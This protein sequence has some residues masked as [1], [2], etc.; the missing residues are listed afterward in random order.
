LAVLSVFRSE[1]VDLQKAIVN[2]LPKFEEQQT[3]FISQQLL[4]L[5]GKECQLTQMRV[6]P[7]KPK[8]PTEYDFWGLLP[9]QHSDFLDPFAAIDLLGDARAGGLRPFDIMLEAK[10]KDL[11]L[12][13]LREQIV[14]FAPELVGYIGWLV[15]D[16]KLTCPGEH[17]AAPSP[18]GQADGDSDSSLLPYR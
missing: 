1:N 7:S 5:L 3:H 10:A 9:H 4:V 6:K 16:R 15:I 8:R 17:G 18:A 11:A 14:Q 12:L 2:R 13:R